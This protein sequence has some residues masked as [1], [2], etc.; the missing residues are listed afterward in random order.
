MSALDWM[1][2][3]PVCLP[4]ACEVTKGLEIRKQELMPQSGLGGDQ[5]CS[6]V[7]S[8]A[9]ASPPPHKASKG[10][11]TLAA[12]AQVASRLLGHQFR[13]A[14]LRIALDT[15]LWTPVQPRS[16]VQMSL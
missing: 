4:W 13:D 10:V 9:R 16:P 12:S 5:G 2:S 7:S 15:I 3:A 11:K 6:G 14:L 1:L 8:G